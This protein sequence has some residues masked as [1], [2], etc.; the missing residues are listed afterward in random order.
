MRVGLQREEPDIDMNVGAARWKRRWKRALLV[1]VLAVSRAVAQDSGVEAARISPTLYFGS[2]RE[3]R[4]SREAQHVRVAAFEKQLAA[5]SDDS[6]PDLL[7]TG[8]Q[9][10]ISL[11]RHTAYLRIQTLEDTTDEAA[12][13]AANAVNTDRSVT[14]TALR[15]RLAR[16]PPGRIAS[17]GRFARLAEISHRDEAHSVSPDAAR[18]RGSVT[19]AAQTS[20]A[21]AYNRLVGAIGNQGTGSHDMATR[22]TAIARRDEAYDRAAPTAATLLGTL[23]DLQNRDAV[24][25][26]YTDAADRKYRSLELSDALVTKTLAAVQAQSAVYQEYRQVLAERASLVLGVSPVL[27]AEVA[28]GGTPSPRISL[29]Q[30]RELVLDALAPLGAEYVGRFAELLDPANGRL[31][32]AGGSHRARTGTSIAVYDAPVAFFFTGFNGLLPSVGTIAHEGGHAIHRELMNVGGAPIYERTGPNYLFEGFAIFN[33]LL[34]FEHA[35]RIAK[36]PTERMAA[37]EALLQ[38][39]SFELFVSA[40]EAAFERSLYK[41]G[42]GRALLDRGAVDEIYRKAIAPYEDRPGETAVSGE[43]MRKP[44]L[45][46][47]PLYLVN[48]LYAQIVAVGLYNRSRDDPNFASEYSA[49][50]RRGFDAD[51]EVLLGSLKIRLDDPKLVEAAAH[52][53]RSKTQELRDLYRAQVEPAK[54]Q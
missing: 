21:D 37:L 3:E 47:D 10:L 6:L 16:V 31:D 23:I 1:A 29:S 26:R 28:L 50:L 36:N 12:N 49:L 22:R 34:A 44:L 14:S 8:E 20:I 53:I 2:A 40:E 43:W 54:H 30:A 13:A 19:I 17:L 46:E 38:S 51:T 35:A 39:L 41:A 42:S 25:Q 7:A 52:L 24:A 27:P 32:L 45:F 5:A 18:Y 4:E 33:Q 11:Q 15:S 48:Y 9:L